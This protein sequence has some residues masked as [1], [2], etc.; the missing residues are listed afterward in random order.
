MKCILPTLIYSY[1]SVFGIPV[2]RFAVANA[3]LQDIARYKA[4][5]E[6]AR[7]SLLNMQQQLEQL[8]HHQE[9]ISLPLTPRLVASVLG[10][11]RV[12]G[13]GY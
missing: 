10:C 1:A 3:P 5:A 2:G 8:R 6:E 11:N 12:E 4:E 9:H 13:D 7:R